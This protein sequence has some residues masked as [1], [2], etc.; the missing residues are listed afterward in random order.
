MQS[1]ELKL[2]AGIDAAI[3]RPFDALLRC[4]RRYALSALGPVC[5]SGAHFL[6]A[7]LVLHALAPAQFG[8]FSFVMT[9]VPFCI[10]A[11]A[12]LI[13][14]PTTIGIRTRGHVDAVELAT[15]Q[16]AN[17]V[18]SLLA[19]AVVSAA[20]LASGLGTL[21]AALFGLY[22]ATMSL[23]WLGRVYA[24]A[25]NT[26]ARAAGSDVAYAG[27][28][29]AG[30]GTLDL[31]GC[32]SLTGA[33]VAMFVAAAASL[34][35][36]DRAYLAKQFAPSAAGRLAA[37]GPVWRELTRWSLLGVAATELTIN[38]HAYFVTFFSGPGAFAVLALGGLLMRPV[39]VVLASLPDMERPV[40]ARAIGAGDVS[41]AFRAVKE[42][43][44]AAAAILGV[45]TLTA[46]ALLFWFPSLVLKQG[47]DLHAAAIIVAIWV[48]IMTV[49][50]LRTPEAVF[51][52]AAG[53]FRA[54]ADIGIKSS[55]VSL[56]A[57]LALL[58]AFGPIAS[59]LGIVA[60]DLAMTAGIFARVRRWKL[61][62][63]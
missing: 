48:A 57:T 55:L 60:G 10:S 3:G 54:L 17:L 56:V 33:A 31:T 62:H 4:A 28:L 59:L 52:Q 18:L 43:R 22:G 47:Y 6:G 46:A 58:L 24:Y 49:R 15:F 63:G 2:E 19:F 38:A 50:A 32:L 42:F 21:A 25:T 61:A 26:P 9:V 11:A 16:K 39:A 14:A 12:A 5:I 20:L 34:A 44:T 23:R 8:L 36:F 7:V 27:L 41:R 45:T 30:F 35:I 1:A 53:E 13:G 29:V 37:Y 51:L 40:M